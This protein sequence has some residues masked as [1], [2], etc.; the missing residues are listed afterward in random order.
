MR[1]DER[2]RTHVALL[3]GINVSGRNK[4]SMVELRQIVESMGG[5]D[6]ASYIQ[7][8]N[9]VFSAPD[10][11]AD[12]SAL[13]HELEIAIAERLDVHPA[14]VVVA[15]DELAGVVRSNPFPEAGDHRLLHAVFFR[16]ELGPNEVA[17]VGA[18]VDRA[19]IKGSRDEA[20]VIGRTLYL[21]TPE[22][23]VRSILGSELGRGGQYRT[24]MKDGTA[25]NW[26]T[27]NALLSLLER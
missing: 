19:R 11:R 15:R 26:R 13:A 21:W 24:P 7:S 5:R 17:S 14:V 20:R 18:A 16:D 9:V 4:V 27:V 1:D 6:V 3:R 2:V 10:P 23:F 22:G 25:R 12:T 8:G